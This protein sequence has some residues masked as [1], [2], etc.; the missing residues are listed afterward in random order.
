MKSTTARAVVAVLFSISIMIGFFIDKVTEEVF[1][2]YATL[3][4]GYFFGKGDTTDD[5]AQQLDPDHKIEQLAAMSAGNN[6]ISS[7]NPPKLGAGFVR[8]LMAL[9]L[10]LGVVWG[11]ITGLLPVTIF[12][13][14]AAT[15]T[16]YYFGK[17]KDHQPTPSVEFHNE[18]TVKVFDQRG[19]DEEDVIH[20]G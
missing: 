2:M 15:A 20:L 8:G 3:V 14:F 17:D 19:L 18:P 5:T 10:M 11:Y 6:K 7:I 13:N 4:L 1:T 16:G 9:G 12:V